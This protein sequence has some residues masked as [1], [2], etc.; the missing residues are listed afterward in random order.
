MKH[1]EQKPDSQNDS[2]PSETAG[3]ADTVTFTEDGLGEKSLTDSARQTDQ[4]RYVIGRELA[5]GGLGRNF[6]ARDSRLDRQVAIKELLSSSDKLRE[7]FQREA[8][9]TARLQHPAI[10]PVYDSG[11]RENGEPFYVM[12]LLSGGHTLKELIDHKKTFDERLTLLPNCIAVADAIAYAHSLGIIHRDLKPS[13]VLIGPFG[14]T[15]V[16]DWGLAKDLCKPQVGARADVSERLAS[17]DVTSAGSILGTPQ[18]MAPEQARGE[19]V[20]KGADVYALG[21]ILYHTL[22]GHAPYA[23]ADARDILDRVLAGNLVPLEKRQPG[24]PTEL[25]TIVGKA[26]ADKPRDRY[27]SAAEL[28]ADLKRFQTGQLVSA[29]EYSTLTLLARQLRKHRTVVLVAA[30][31]LALLAIVSGIGVRRVVAERDRAQRQRAAAE[32]LTQFVLTDLHDRLE[33]LGKLDL[34]RGT[35]DK[36]EAYYQK[37]EQASGGLDARQSVHQL[38]ALTITG[39]VQR[40]SGKSDEARA[41]FNRVL[42]LGAA[43]TPSAGS[44]T[45]VAMA[46]LRLGVISSNGGDLPAADKHY[47]AGLDLIDR[48]LNEVPDDYGALRVKADLM[49][50]LAGQEL[51][52]GTAEA[53]INWNRQAIA[54]YDRLQRRDANDD[55]VMEQRT[56][57]KLDLGENL[58]RVGQRDEA[59]VETRSAETLARRLLEKDPDNARWIELLALVEWYLG[60]VLLRGGEIESALKAQREAL[61]LRERVAA[62]DPANIEARNK[63]AESYRLLAGTEVAARDMASAKRDIRRSLDITEALASKEPQEMRWRYSLWYDQLQ[64]GEIASVT[65]PA[66]ALESYRAAAESMGKLVAANPE[67]VRSAANLAVTRMRVGQTLLKLG[68]VDEAI[69]TLAET[70]RQLSDRLVAQPYNHSIFVTSIDCEGALAEAEEARGQHARASAHLTAALQRAESRISKSPDDVNVL[71]IMVRLYRDQGEL[72]RGDAAAARAAYEKGLA[73][74]SQLR[75][76]Q[77]LTPEVTELEAEIKKRLERLPRMKQTGTAP[78]NRP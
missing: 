28:A 65:A 63:V 13:N 68:R 77:Q 72:L 39:D 59:L 23:G 17:P 74:V 38:R 49:L 57:T 9:I 1:G 33:G 56:S 52:H 25:A 55:G 21:A 69:A 24:V 36:V 2:E 78:G 64:E 3:L 40:M 75:E 70:T 62:R 71:G 7:R 58:I 42:A 76:K 14:E 19:A 8:G 43:V 54:I 60:D 4:S 11:S 51:L 10:V 12:K 45:V 53:A 30:V 37:M 61:S 6:V 47:L 46:R 34:M 18:Y 16:I 41:A 15:V 35:S 22:S 73:I 31:L 66:Q 20:D 5:R 50:K 27:A 48:V 44:R 29:H 26:M 32:E 67:S